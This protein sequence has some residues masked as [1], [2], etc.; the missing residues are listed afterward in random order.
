[1]SN[2]AIGYFSKKPLIEELTEFE[3]TAASINAPPEYLEGVDAVVNKLKR[4]EPDLVIE[5]GE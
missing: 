5:E 3:Q 4:K 1:M 2:N